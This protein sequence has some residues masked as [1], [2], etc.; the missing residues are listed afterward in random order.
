MKVNRNRHIRPLAI[1][2]LGILMPVALSSTAQTSVTG[3]PVNIEALS[4]PLP[5]TQPQPW[6]APRPDSA[7]LPLAEGFNVAQFE[8][9]AQQL[10]YGNRVPG[11][12]M[13]IVHD[14]RVISARGYGV[15]DVI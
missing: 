11:L 7:V 5:P 4:A 9:M 8:A 14:G 6:R 13:A 12:S 10:T 3:L 15:T 2:L 1:G